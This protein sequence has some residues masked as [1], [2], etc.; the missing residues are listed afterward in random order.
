MSLEPLSKKLCKGDHVENNE[1]TSFKNLNVVRIL[2]D[3]PE[4]KAA[5]IHG[6]FEGRDE[7]AV[8][9]VEKTPF[10]AET[11]QQ[12]L[13][14]DTTLTTHHINDIYGTYSGYPKPELND[15]KAT[16]IF[17]ATEK[18]IIKYTDQ[19]IHAINETGDD[20]KI[21]TLP[22]LKKQDFHIQWV[23]NILEKKA[24]TERVLFEDPD[25][26]IGFVL[27]PDMK[28][29]KKHM[30]NMYMLAICHRRD[31]LSL[32]DL[33]EE[34]LPMLRNI[35]SKGLNAIKEAYGVNEDQVKIY[36]HYQPSYY[37]LHVHFTHLKFNAPGSSVGKAYL[38]TDVIDNIVL[39]SNYYQ[40]KTLTFVATEADPLYLEF[41]KARKATNHD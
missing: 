37:H 40:G 39:M 24:E 22:Y 14:S 36:L 29:D 17:P 1:F 35:L 32:R 2:Q 28:W 26:K 18:H 3:K 30:E 23:Y 10:S 8:V 5:F 16:I 21:V 34:H 4:S 12:V 38:L 41:V 25:P 9:I 7:D 33:T 31:V 19:P 27:L 20:Y 15:I 11:I 6:R 13:S